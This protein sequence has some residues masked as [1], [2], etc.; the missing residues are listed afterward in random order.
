VT[1]HEYQQLQ[2]STDAAA[3]KMAHVDLNPHP[4][5]PSHIR[6]SWASAPVRASSRKMLAACTQPETW[7]RMRDLEKEKQVRVCR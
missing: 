2:R 3:A 1:E 4:T 6:S 7:A 5:Q